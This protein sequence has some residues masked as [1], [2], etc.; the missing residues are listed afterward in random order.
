MDDLEALRRQFDRVC[1]FTDFH[2]DGRVWWIYL[3][4]AVG[5]VVVKYDLPELQTVYDRMK[6]APENLPDEHV[7]WLE[8]REAVARALVKTEK[9]SPV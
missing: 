6:E 9:G 8:L 2:P 5:K 1:L 4:E 3:R 7:H